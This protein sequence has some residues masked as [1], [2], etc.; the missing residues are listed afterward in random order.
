[1][2]LGRTSVWEYLARAEAAGVRYEDIADKSEAEIEA[3]L[4]KRP[5]LAGFAA[6][7]G[8]GGGRGGV[9]VSPR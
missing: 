8:L 9:C 2:R 5:E 1:M 3:L 4:F 7:A 6:P